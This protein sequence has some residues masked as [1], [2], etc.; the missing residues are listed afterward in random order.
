MCQADLNEDVGAVRDLQ[1]QIDNAP[2]LIHMHRLL[3]SMVEISN[4]RD[5]DALLE[6][7]FLGVNDDGRKV[8]RLNTL[9]LLA[10]PDRCLSVTQLVKEIRNIAGVTNADIGALL[11]KVKIHLHLNDKEDDGSPIVELFKRYN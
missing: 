10:F 11:A 3:G 9:R 7:I 1:N 2:N 6:G 5:V 4:R 8:I